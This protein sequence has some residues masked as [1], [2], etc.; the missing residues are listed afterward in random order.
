MNI[1]KKDER[2]YATL[3]YAIKTRAET[4]VVLNTKYAQ[5]ISCEGDLLHQKLIAL[6]ANEVSEENLDYEMLRNTTVRQHLKKNMD[7]QIINENRRRQ[8]DEKGIRGRYEKKEND[9]EGNIQEK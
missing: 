3:C 2:K 1:P 4:K 6:I 9:L 5:W 8:V 7:G